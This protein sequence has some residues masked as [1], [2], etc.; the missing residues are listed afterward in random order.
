MLIFFIHGVATR[1]VKY[2]HSLIDGIK[3][4][5]NQVG[6][7]LPYFYTSFWGHILNDFNKVWN[8]IDED[9]NFFERNNPAINSEDAF[10][11]RQF[12]EG[13]I[14]EFTGDMFTYMN[15]RQG[16]EVRQLLADQLI[17]FVEQHPEEEDLHI[18]AHSLGTVILWD[19]LFSDKFADGDPA[20]LIRDLISGKRVDNRTKGI[21]LSSITT[22]GS[23]ILFFNVMLGIDSKKI[24]SKI[25]S[26]S[27]QEIQ[28]LNVIHASDLIAYP[29]SASL[30]LSLDSNL[31]F[32]DLFICKDANLLE[33][34]ARRINQQ[35]VALMAAM[36]EAHNSY[37]KLPEV[38]SLIAKQI[39]E[40][41]K[42]SEKVA[43]LL[44][45]VSGMS[46][47]G[48][49]LHS[50]KDLIDNI[51]FKDKSGRLECMQNL[52]GIHHVYIYDNAGRCI[53]S[54]FVDWKYADEL[55][56]EIEYIR[57]KFGENNDS[58]K[59]KLKQSRIK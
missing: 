53:F 22:M 19:I 14:S 50:S 4:E 51:E 47:V 5:F 44:Q 56:D 8:H 29:L 33:S 34:A 2:A 48:L 27:K 26:Y 9:L 1:D 15:E 52:I 55:L 11:Y 24:E 35:E 41:I 42:F 40:R 17:K 38:V 7:K 30:K 39:I 54:G 32:R 6:Q 37:W 10:R 36:V 43:L 49:K 3:K 46:A 57:W 13:L 45:N 21:S 25:Q 16:Y 23:P 58:K 59:I 28:W 31:I 12:R 20:Y 18:I